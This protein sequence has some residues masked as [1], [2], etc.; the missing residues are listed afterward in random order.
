MKYPSSEINL[1][2]KSTTIIHECNQE[3]KQ[4]RLIF[5][6]FHEALKKLQY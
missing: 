5:N 1:N 6:E 3:K 4:V 2:N